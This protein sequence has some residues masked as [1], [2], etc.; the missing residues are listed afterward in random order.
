MATGDES[1]VSGKVVRTVLLIIVVL[2]ICGWTWKVFSFVRGSYPTEYRDLATIQL[3]Q[4]FARNENPYSPGNSPPFFYVYGFLFS[5]LLSP[6]ARLASG[7]PLLLHKIAVLFS[8]LCA[9][10]LMSLEVRRNTRSRLLQALGFALMLVTAWNTTPFII[11]PDSF[12]LLILLLIPFVLRRSNSYLTIAL[13]AFLTI[14]T[15]YTKQY[16]LFIAA[17]VFLYELFEDWRK[18]VFLLAV[19]LLLGTGS[20]FLVRAVFSTFF[21]DCLA[22]QV[23]STRGSLRHLLLQSLA[24][25]ARAWPLFLLMCYPAGRKIL[26]A[27]AETPNQ[28]DTAAGDESGLRIYYLMFAVAAV[29]LVFL[30]TNRG[31]WL[32]Y[33]Y[34]LAWPSLIVVG[35]SMLA[36]IERR[37]WQPLFLVCIAVFSLFYAVDEIRKGRLDFLSTVSKGDGF[38]WERAKVILDQYKSPQMLLSPIFADYISKNGLEPVDNGNTEYY[39]NLGATGRTLK[40]K[41]LTS[42]LPGIASQFG[43]FEAWRKRLSEN[44]RKQGYS[45]IAVLTQ[46]HPLIDQDDLEKHYHRID[47]LHLR[48]AAEHDWEVGF[49]VPNR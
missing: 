33:Y 6:F 44:I 42:L 47:K 41:L 37:L 29:C 46:H 32:S 4:L 48:L 7:N 27:G 14:T 18:A 26:R 49:W 1:P 28:A 22:G 9:S 8:V 38:S 12:G 25:A 24:F 11:R 31:A 20:V 35:L 45:M 36:K 15:F 13:C 19:T 5:L 16:F 10:F 3:T 30:G 40:M 21:I 23:D 43:R 17:P 39:G 2:Y 34:Q